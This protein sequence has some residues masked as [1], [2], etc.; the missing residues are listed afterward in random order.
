[1][2]G[3]SRQEANRKLADWAKSQDLATVNRE[4]DKTHQDLRKFN[5]KSLDYH[6]ISKRQQE[7][8]RALD[9]S[10]RLSS[11]G[12]HLNL[13]PSINQI[14]SNHQSNLL[15]S[16]SNLQSNQSNQSDHLNHSNHHH[17]QHQ[18]QLEIINLKNQLILSKNYQDDLKSNLENLKFQ[19]DQERKSFDRERKLLLITIKK[20]QSEVD[21]GWNRII[22]LRNLYEKSNQISENSQ[23]HPIY[24]SDQ[25]LEFTYRPKSSS[26]LSNWDN[27]NFLSKK[28]SFNNLKNSSNYQNHQRVASFDLPSTHSFNHHN[29][30]KSHS[31]NR[32]SSFS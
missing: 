28:L 8:S 10:N 4:I 7:R 25:S 9:A 12:I 32:T 13:E 11:L 31:R 14:F 3:W 27:Q 2:P 20:L 6:Y 29:L 1:M 18:Q 24:E 21:E 19:R 16:N 5:N 15:K 17:Q 30:S 22:K 26:N 23:Y